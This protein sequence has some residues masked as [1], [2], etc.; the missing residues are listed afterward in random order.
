[1]LQMRRRRTD[2]AAPD[3]RL[4]RIAISSII[5][6]RR[7]ASQR[8]PLSKTALLVDRARNLSGAKLLI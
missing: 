7:N 1:M 5:F 6:A 3:R 4:R 2:Q 8:L